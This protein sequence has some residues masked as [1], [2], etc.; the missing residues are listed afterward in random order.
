MINFCLASLLAFLIWQFI[1]PL[2]LKDGRTVG[3]KLFGLAVVRTNCVKMSTPVLFVRSMV[4]L[5]A[6]ETMAVAFLCLLGTVGIIAAILVQVLQIWVLVKT[7][8]QSIHDL[9]SDTVV[10]DYSSQQ[11]FET[12]EELASFL[13]TEKLNEV[14]SEETY[15]T[16]R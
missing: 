1:L 15:E 16:Q 9:L 2:I 7:P 10:V 6:M 4:G 3:K 5:Y 8:M 14:P 13:A 11:I 12:Q